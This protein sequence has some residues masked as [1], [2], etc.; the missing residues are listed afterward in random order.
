MIDIPGE[1]NAMQR[2]VA[3]RPFGSGDGRTVLIRRAYDAPIEEVWDAVTNPDRIK[4]WFLPVSGDLRLG[5]SYQLQ[6]N[7]HGE[8]LRCEPPRL[9]KVT[10][11]F[12]ES[13]SEVEVRLSAGD[14]GTAFE[15]AHALP[16]DDHW[17]QF[18]PGA[19]GVGWDLTMLGLG[20][21]LRGG[22]IDDPE[23]WVRSAEAREFM[24]LSSRSW[25]TAHQ[26]SGVSPEE[27]SAA[28]KATLQAY[29]G[30]EPG[31][32]DGKAED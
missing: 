27:A 30:E 7:A 19:V 17:G 16:L 20:L 24:T 3:N 21:H 14:N 15:L 12:G 18:G 10:W 32:G 28:E 6:G 9:L 31:P 11:I 23:A 22:M 1:I 29:V 5:G 8:I 25:G 26:G 13:T 4:R 2:E